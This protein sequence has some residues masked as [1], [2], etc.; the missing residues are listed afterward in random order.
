[1][2]DFS[3]TYFRNLFTHYS[4]NYCQSFPNDNW[5]H[6]LMSVNERS[7]SLRNKACFSW[8]YIA[9]DVCSLFL[10]G[11]PSLPF[12][13]NFSNV[14]FQWFWLTSILYKYNIQH[15]PPSILRLWAVL[16]ISVQAATMSLPFSWHQYFWVQP[17]DTLYNLNTSTIKRMLYFLFHDVKIL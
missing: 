4:S 11:L 2:L 5:N 9:H 6:T 1:M 14:F 10:E 15:S 8:W 16:R 17:P 13:I 7:L 12:L 3:Y